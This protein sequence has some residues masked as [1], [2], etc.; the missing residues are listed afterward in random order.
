MRREDKEGNP[1]MYCIWCEE[2]KVNNIF[3]KG[4]NKFKK[5]YLDNHIKTEQ[6]I[7]ISKLRNNANQSNIITSFVTQLGIEK[8]KV[9]ALMRNAYFCSK[10]NLALN[11]YPDLNNLV[12][13]QIKNHEEIHHQILPIKVLPPPLHSQTISLTSTSTSSNYATY[14]NPKAGL[15]FIESL[16]YVIERQVIEEIN[17]SIGWSILLDESTTITIDKHLVIISK[18]M[19]G[20]EPV[21]R[22]LGMI[23]LEE[24]DANSIM[25]DISI[26]LNAKGISFQNLYHIG[27]DG[28]SVMTG[29][30]FY[31]LFNY[32]IYLYI[33]TFSFFL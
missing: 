7:S 18:H 26:F 10:Q 11:V 13:Y 20:N 1:F 33:F 9:I 8:S 28:A 31:K 5:D 6:H 19:V 21:L 2:G 15:N 29:K 25:R 12:E 3:T 16:S 32:F 14:K 24:C 22:Y 27:S 30:L 23:N 4:C 17:K